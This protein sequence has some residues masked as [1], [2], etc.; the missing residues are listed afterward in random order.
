MKKNKSNDNSKKIVKMETCSTGWWHFLTQEDIDREQ[1]P[2][3]VKH[4][5][6]RKATWER[7]SAE[8]G[9]SQK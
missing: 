8:D 3:Q 7:L 5:K 1:S 9:N 4:R 2:L 6:L